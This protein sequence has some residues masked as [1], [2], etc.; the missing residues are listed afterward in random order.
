MW[1]RRQLLALATLFGARTAQASELLEA[2]ELSLPKPGRFG[3]KCLLLRPSRVPADRP[4]PLL[5][6]FHG[7]GETG[8]EALGIRAWYERYGLREAYARLAAPPIERTLPQQRY[9]SDQRLSALNREL[10]ATPFPDLAIACPFTP[11][12]M[13]LQPSSPHLD[14]YAEYIEQQLLPAVRES[15][16]TLPGSEHTGVDGV[17]LGGYVSLEIFLR[18][19]QL[20]GVVGCVQGA[21]GLA[22]AEVYA[23]KLTEAGAPRVHVVTSSQDPF[24]SGA[25][26]LA[27]RLGERGAAAT[28]TDSEGPHDQRYLREAGTLEML[29]YQARALNGEAV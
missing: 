12:V 19:P 11:N 1:S 14:R 24:R 8:S 7:L 28:L 21:F 29:L 26:R 3:S 27:Q 6:L 13:K 20:F 25:L 23:R 16:P 10:G 15:T 17:S 5:V 9:L 4:L 18:R 22:M 2:R